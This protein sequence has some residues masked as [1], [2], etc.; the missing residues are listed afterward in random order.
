MLDLA[1]NEETKEILPYSLDSYDYD[2]ET[3][4]YNIKLGYVSEYD[5][6]GMPWKDRFPR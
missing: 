1:F 4:I 5:Y 3:I 6:D 2:S